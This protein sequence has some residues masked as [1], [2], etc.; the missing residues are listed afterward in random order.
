MAS[1]G[2]LIPAPD[3][4]KR[5]RTRRDRAVADLFLCLAPDINALGLQ[6]APCPS[7]VYAST[8][9]SKHK[10][11]LFV[12]AENYLFPFR[13]CGFFQSF[14]YSVAANILCR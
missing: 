7:C 14:Q 13:P 9:R 2:A 12:D 6:P 10:T 11:V 4:G 5:R 3:E 8:V 1:F